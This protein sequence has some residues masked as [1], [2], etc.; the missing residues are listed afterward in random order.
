MKGTIVATRNGPASLE[1][2]VQIVND[3][4]SPATLPTGVAN[5]ISLAVAKGLDA[6]A[7]R[8]R[9]RAEIDMLAVQQQTEV[10][11]GAANT[12]VGLEI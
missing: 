1:L 4:G 3:D 12:L 7:I 2:T 6:D 11:H 9:V 8:A 10:D 5:P